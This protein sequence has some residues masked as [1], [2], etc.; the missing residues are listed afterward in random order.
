MVDFDLLLNI[1]YSSLGG[2][3]EGTELLAMV[4][5]WASALADSYGSRPLDGC[6]HH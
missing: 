6:R 4:V 2:A 1:G 3:H 5:L